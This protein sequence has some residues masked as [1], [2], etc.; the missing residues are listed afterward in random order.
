MGWW[1]GTDWSSQSSQSNLIL[2][3][4]HFLPSFSFNLLFS[5]IFCQSFTW[6]WPGM[7]I[8]C[9]RFE[10]GQ[11]CQVAFLPA[12]HGWRAENMA[13][14]MAIDVW[15]RS[16]IQ[17][18]WHVHLPHHMPCSFSFPH[19]LHLLPYICQVQVHRKWHLCTSW[20]SSPD[21]LSGV[22]RVHRCRPAGTSGF[23]N[24]AYIFASRNGRSVVGP[25]FAS[26]PEFFFCQWSC[27][28]NIFIFLSSVVAADRSVHMP[29]AALLCCRFCARDLFP[30]ILPAPVHIAVHSIVYMP[31]NLCLHSLIERTGGRWIKLTNDGDGLLSRWYSGDW[32]WGLFYVC[33]QSCQYIRTWKYVDR[34]CCSIL[35]GIY[36][37]FLR[38]WY[39][40]EYIN[41]F[42]ASRCGR[43]CELNLTPDLLA[44]NGNAMIE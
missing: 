34:R 9:F 10:D 40:I 25:V 43:S 16:S 20:S 5:F 44:I 38:A 31:L 41:I 22:G 39:S 29:A 6:Q 11:C 12:V 17:S 24:A 28:M 7:V 32:W 1:N 15:S 14:R 19:F 3:H 4:C 33:G 26:T 27:Q 13:R 18:A 2:V 21:V 30:H 23:S 36:V 42:H 8:F 35:L 37:A